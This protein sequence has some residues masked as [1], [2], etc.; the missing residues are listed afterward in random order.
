MSILGNSVQLI[1][2]LGKDVEIKT[3]NTGSKKASFTLATTE[4]Y[5]NPKGELVKNTQW[6]NIIAWGNT[7]EAMQKN[8]TKGSKV[9]ILG[10]ISYRVYEDKAGVK[11]SITE[12]NTNEFY[13]I[14]ST[15]SVNQN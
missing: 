8:L 2:H 15:E 11:K 5:K 12:I 6:H 1:G 3:F 9:A 10:T 13:K 7:A 14:V 4:V